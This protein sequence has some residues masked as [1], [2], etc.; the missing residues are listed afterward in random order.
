MGKHHFFSSMKSFVSLLS[1]SSPFLLV[2]LTDVGYISLVLHSMDDDARKQLSP[3]KLRRKAAKF[4][5]DTVKKQ[6]KSFKVI[7]SF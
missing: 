2:M 3:L 5:I 1:H 7:L 4:A 6:M